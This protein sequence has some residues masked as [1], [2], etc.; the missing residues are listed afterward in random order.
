MPTKFP[1][2]ERTG[3][4][5]L[6]AHYKCDLQEL[7]GSVRSRYQLVMLRVIWVAG[8]AQPTPSC[9]ILLLEKKNMISNLNWFF[10]NYLI[11]KILYVILY[12]YM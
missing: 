7:L 9:Y 3:K 12:T 6:P 11:I 1:D 10:Q 4:C 2:T 5:G 8:K